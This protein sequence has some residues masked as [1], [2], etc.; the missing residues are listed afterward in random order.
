MMRVKI[1]SEAKG[2]HVHMTVRAGENEGSLGLCGLLVMRVGEWQLFGAALLLGAQR[3]CGH[4]QVEL[5]GQDS[6]VRAL[7]EQSTA[8]ER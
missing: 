1:V 6:V 7:V 4:L 2:E 8:A 5:P 3:M